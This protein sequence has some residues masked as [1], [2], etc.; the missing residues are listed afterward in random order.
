[1]RLVLL[2][3]L[4]AL[5]ASAN[6][7]GII[8]EAEAYSAYHNEGGNPIMWVDCGAASGGRAV[9]GLDYPGDWI[10]VALTIGNGSFT[11]RIRSA[12]L[13]D[14]TSTIG[15]TVFGAGP[16]GVDLNSTF[17]TYGLGIG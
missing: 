7:Q 5:A 6:A 9:E 11:D 16:G 14:S 12:G 3:G 17:S 13:F 2:V 10:E 15:S 8:V 4:V 1:M